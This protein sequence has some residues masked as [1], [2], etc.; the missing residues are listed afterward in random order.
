[1]APPLQVDGIDVFVE[2]GGS[3]SIV[4]IH[5]WPDTYRLW[6]AQ[7]AFF[8]DGY[9]CVR[10]TL[11]GF[12]IGEPR[13]A[14]SLA[15]LLAIARHV[16]E[17]TSPGRKVILM[18][19][20]WGCAFGYQLAMRHPELVSKIIGVDIGDAGT[21][22]HVRSLS[23]KAKVMVIAYQLWLALAWQIGGGIGD[24]M[25][26]WMARIARA[27]SDPRLIGARMNYPYYI[28]WMGAH[29]GY[30]DMVRFAPPCPMLFVYGERKPFLFHTRA[31]ADALAAKPRNRVS[32]LQTGHW[33]MNER[34]DE[35]NRAVAA[36]LSA[37]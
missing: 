4:M 25:T 6:D 3:E 1:M 8:K 26:L 29:G 36:W 10:F 20:D 24:R 23:A 34:P 2:G 13:R 31:W 21:R 33:V 17:Q 9:R 27:P 28:R 7:V 14:Y 22:E 18:L 30:R 32:A 12:D 15:D 5:G 37:A 11:P 16:I 19:H 35:F